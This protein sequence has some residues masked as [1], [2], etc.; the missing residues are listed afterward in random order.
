MH[1]FHPVSNLICSSSNE[2]IQLASNSFL[3]G[4]ESFPPQAWHCFPSVVIA[5]GLLLSPI[6]AK[7]GNTRGHSVSFR[8]FLVSF[9]RWLVLD[10][11]LFDVKSESQKCKE[12]MTVFLIGALSFRGYCFYSLSRHC[13]VGKKTMSW[14]SCCLLGWCYFGT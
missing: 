8:F 1:W 2:E 6:G 13:V 4:V 12:Q 9:C 5:Q 7:K 11:A 10:S 3:A 14:Y